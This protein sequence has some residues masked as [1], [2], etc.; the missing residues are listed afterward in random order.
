MTGR[1][2]TTS[3]HTMPSNTPL[4]TR[5]ADAPPAGSSDA[6]ATSSG[7]EAP[8][9]IDWPRWFVVIGAIIGLSTILIV[10]PMRGP[11]EFSHLVR[12]STIGLGYLAPP[13]SDANPADY[14]VDGCLVA[15]HESALDR[16]RPDG[17]VG[18]G[19]QFDEPTCA[20]PEPAHR[21]GEAS[22]IGNTEVN[23]PLAYAPAAIG[24]RIGQAVGGVVW[25]QYLA[26]VCQLVAYLALVWLALRLLPFGRPF[27]AAVGLIPAAIQVA[28]T[29]SAD[30]V[31]AGLAFVVTAA[32]LRFVHR[33]AEG[34]P[35]A[36][37]DELVGYCACV[38]LLAACKTAV[39]PIIGLALLVPT[40]IFGS[41]RRRVAT[42]VLTL[43]VALAFAVTW[44]RAVVSHVRISMYI[45]ADS[46]AMRRWILNHPVD[47]VLATWRGWTDAEWV[48]MTGSTLITSV[49]V[50]NQ[51]LWLV[52]LVLAALGVA[53]FGDLPAAM[54]R[55]LGGRDAARPSTGADRVAS[56]GPGSVTD[57]RGAERRVDRRREPTARIVTGVVVAGVAFAGFWLIELGV[58]LSVTAPG[59]PKIIAIQGRY[60]LPYLPLLLF[61]AVGWTTGR[62]AV[63]RVASIV[64]VALLVGVNAWWLSVVYRTYYI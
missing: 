31:S 44:S 57:E 50:P 51:P 27:L 12:A 47:F 37:R 52:V 46:I 42:L 15:L 21:P 3:P 43:G 23:P 34:G 5:P 25:G 20:Q 59:S 11:D 10:P 30:P 22:T 9:E 26:R 2:S 7:D 1:R 64:P 55:R 63:R 58:A 24:F 39:L 45:G 53:Y 8:R 6:A 17:R 40:A 32:T 13:P 36:S 48:H 61:A 62:R 56:S 35:A 29:V 38:V 16:A 28:S 60:F 33:A 18:W 19:R 14:Q 49:I 41:R 54:T 4:G